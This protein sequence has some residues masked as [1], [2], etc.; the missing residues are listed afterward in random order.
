VIDDRLENAGLFICEES[1]VLFVFV[2]CLL[3]FAQP[4]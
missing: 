2:F 4:T 1:F 3:S